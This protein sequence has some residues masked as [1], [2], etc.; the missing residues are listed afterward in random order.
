MQRLLVKTLCMIVHATRDMV[1]CID[2]P[3]YQPKLIRVLASSEAN[4]W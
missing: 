2:R 4:S 3:K 1:R